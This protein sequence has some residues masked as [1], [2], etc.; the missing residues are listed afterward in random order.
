MHFD[1]TVAGHEARQRPRELAKRLARRLRVISILDDDSDR[2]V[3]MHL[4]G[5][6]IV[7]RCADLR[8]L[9]RLVEE[10]GYGA[11]VLDPAIGSAD[12]TRQAMMIL[13][14]SAA[15][16][17][18]WLEYETIIAS[19]V[20]GSLTGTF[21]VVLRDLDDSR[22]QLKLLL[23]GRIQRSIGSIVLSRLF[24]RLSDAP[25]FFTASVA[26]ALTGGSHF[27]T[28]A[29]LAAS[30]GAHQRTLQHCALQRGLRSPR[31][32]LAAGWLARGWEE[33]QV[34]Q[35]SVTEIARVSGAPS[36]KSLLGISHALVGW[37]LAHLRRCRSAEVI[38]E[39]MTA[40]LVSAV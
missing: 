18:V 5:E 27:R 38:A 30:V 39:R 15:R 14:S 6:A 9:R 35:V 7:D 24:E 29:D 11:A 4:G 32:F 21:E 17:I 12:F 33:M 20:L 25:R 37:D 13:A 40:A 26:A 3:R 10:G 1:D 8:T 22:L 36:Y 19:D 31:H 2:A 23:L 16:V 28:V 34:R